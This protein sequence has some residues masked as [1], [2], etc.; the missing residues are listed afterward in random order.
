MTSS[1]RKRRELE[2]TFE[3]T[4]NERT[5]IAREMHDTLL[6]GF[7]GVALHLTTLARGTVH[8]PETR[9]AI[10]RVIA[11][12]QQTL[13]EGRMAVSGLRAVPDG[14][15]DLVDALRSV[16]EETLRSGHVTFR[17][18]L[19]GAPRAI[20]PETELTVLRVTRDAL[21]NVVMHAQ[22]NAVCV[23]VALDSDHLEVTVTDDGRGFVVDE[24]SATAGDHW[25]LVGMRERALEVAGS[26]RV[27]SELGGG[28]RVMLSVPYTASVFRSGMAPA[29]G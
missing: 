22:A 18:E 26:L 11:L 1:G 16:A 10:D 23:R 17:H 29:A 15:R 2:A 19:I 5:R 21:T 12:A 9:H 14:P 28:T 25:G 24:R 8:P 6:Q 27:R 13:T 4:L 3:A 20:E 7:T